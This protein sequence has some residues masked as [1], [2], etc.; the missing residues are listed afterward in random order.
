MPVIADSRYGRLETLRRIG[1]AKDGHKL[2]LCLCDCGNT[3][4]V[5]SNNLITGSVKSCGCIH[6]EYLKSDNMREIVSKTFKNKPKSKE[7]LANFSK[8][9]KGKPA[10][11]KQL[12]HLKTNVWKYGPEH[13]NWQGGKSRRYCYKFNEA[14][15][16][17]V[18]E[19]FGRKCMMPLC[20][21]TEKENGA[22]LDVHHT[23]YNKMQGCGKRPWVLVPL[24]H[25]HHTMTTNSNRWHWFALLYNHWAMPYW[26]NNYQWL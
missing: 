24:C 25:G 14:R 22:K 6:L 3:I 26:N 7:H 1:T 21:M 20:E 11:P 10:S 15:K 9:R 17:Q 18:R 2:W 16:E 12:K 8:A 5:Q 23:D 13:H 19:S 4:E